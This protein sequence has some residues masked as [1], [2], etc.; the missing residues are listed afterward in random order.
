MFVVL[1][2]L[3]LFCSCSCLSLSSS[4]SRFPTSS[5]NGQSTEACAPQPQDPAL[6]CW[7]CNLSPLT[8]LE[9]LLG[10]FKQNRRMYSIEAKEAVTVYSSPSH[11]SS[12]PTQLQATTWFGAPSTGLMH[13]YCMLTPQANAQKR[14]M[15]YKSASLLGCRLTRNK[16]QHDVANTHLCLNSTLSNRKLMWN[17]KNSCEYV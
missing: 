5:D 8:Y 13:L 11:I 1:L 7:A 15:F 16:Y 2:W 9:K 4:Y 14:V 12:D 6:R 3:R 10:S 17:L